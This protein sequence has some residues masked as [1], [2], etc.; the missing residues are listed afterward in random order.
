M[1]AKD[2]LTIIEETLEGKNRK[3]ISDHIGKSKGSVY[4]YQQKFHL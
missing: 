3:E 2:I 4:N 1:D